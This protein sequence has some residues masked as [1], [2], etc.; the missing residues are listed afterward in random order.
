MHGTLENI[1]LNQWDKNFLKSSRR[2]SWVK[3]VTCAALLEGPTF[4]KGRVQWMEETGHRTFEETIKHRRTAAWNPAHGKKKTRQLM[5]GSRTG[6]RTLTSTLFSTLSP[7]TSN[8]TF[9][10]TE[11]LIF[12]P[13]TSFMLSERKKKFHYSP[14]LA[15]KRGIGAEQTFGGESSCSYRWPFTFFLLD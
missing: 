12:L 7:F 1:L 14:S 15:R 3:Q 10:F 5:D 4:N 8:F 6:T 9:F 13:I 11:I 2:F